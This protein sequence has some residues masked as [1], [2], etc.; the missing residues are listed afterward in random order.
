MLYLPTLDCTD[1][2]DRL[3][4]RYA[5]FLSLFQL[6]F[7]SMC[8]AIRSHFFFSLFRCV[9][10]VVSVAWPSSS[11]AIVR[12]KNQKTI[13]YAL[14]LVHEIYRTFGLYTSI[15]LGLSMLHKM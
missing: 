2:S 5:C 11:A 10:V 15:E 14:A 13:E 9:V 7:G 6:E 4:L 1:S 8:C 12:N 3:R